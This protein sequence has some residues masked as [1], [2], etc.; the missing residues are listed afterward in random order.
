[1]GIRVRL[2]DPISRQEFSFDPETA[3]ER[4]WPQIVE[5]MIEGLKPDR[6]EP[7]VKVMLAGSPVGERELVAAA[8]AFGNFCHQAVDP[9]IVDVR[10]GLR[11]AGFLDAHPHAQ[12]VVLSKLG[13][14]ASGA[15]WAGIR[16]GTAIGVVPPAL[17]SIDRAAKQTRALFE[18]SWKR[19]FQAATESTEAG[20]APVAESAEVGLQPISRPPG[21]EAQVRDFDRPVGG[22]GS[23]SGRLCRGD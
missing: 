18:E 21:F 5:T 12:L 17:Q 16:H 11:I 8:I 9:D 7:W 1:M 22:C 3:V 10:E 19:A 15:F 4:F 20:Q 6:W 13:Q 14:L 23:A 2:T